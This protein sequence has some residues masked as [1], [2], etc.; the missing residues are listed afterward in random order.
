MVL[1]C[2]HTICLYYQVAVV[3][4]T[5][6]AWVRLNINILFNI[7]SSKFI[8]VQPVN[9]IYD[10]AFVDYIICAPFSCVRFNFSSVKQFACSCRIPI[11]PL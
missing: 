9:I 3:M 1:G 7:T 11:F 5:A 4:W 6:G 10:C 8:I 2:T